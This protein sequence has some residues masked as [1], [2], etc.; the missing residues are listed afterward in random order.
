MKYNKL[1]HTGL[2]VSVICLGTMTWGQ[3]NTEA[4]GHE[5]M[6]CALD[7]GVN[8]WDT[9]EMYP[10]P[11]MAETYGRTEEIIGTWFEKTG[12]RSEV[13]LASKIAG[14]ARRLPWVRP[15][16]HD[17]ETRLDRA[18][19]LEACDNSLKRLKTDYIDVY[20]LHWPERTTTTFGEMNYKHMPERDGIALEE[21]LR[22]LGEL[23]DAGKVRYVALSNETAWGTMEFLRLAEQHGLPRVV[24]VQNPYNLLM[25]GYEYAMAEVSCR[26]GAGLLAYSPLAMGVLS[27]KYIGGARP[28]GA[29]MTK[30]GDYFPRYMSARAQ[31]ET[32]KYVDIAKKHGLDP[33]QMANT[34]VNMQSF[35]TSNIIGARTMDQLKSNIATGDMTLSDDVLADIETVHKETPIGY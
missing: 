23:V 7:Q 18:S 11:P 27:G 25:R 22:A 16:L 26:T 9:A 3:Q 5:Q 24:S 34:F 35:V 28:E 10:V 12:R 4:E 31:A 21:T 15:H 19:V 33:A 13:I 6:D 2:D 20:Q 30:F 8:F 17:G 14:R 32:V 29:R 1:G